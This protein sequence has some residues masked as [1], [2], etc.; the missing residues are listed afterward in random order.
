MC[1]CERDGDARRHVCRVWFWCRSDEA[2]RIGLA[3][4]RRSGC[5]HSAEVFFRCICCCC[6][7]EQ[8]AVYVCLCMSLGKVSAECSE[9]YVWLEVS[10][11]VTSRTRSTFTHIG[12]A[13]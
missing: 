10:R 2:T 3:G 9:E 12:S 4:A 5:M 11:H 7:Q 8:A 13:R 1:V 6:C